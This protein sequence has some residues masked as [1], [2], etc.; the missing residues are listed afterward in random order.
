[1]NRY[2]VSGLVIAGL[3]L[4]GSTGR[5]P[6]QTGQQEVGDQHL[7]AEDLSAPDKT[8][9]TALKDG[10]KAFAP[11]DKRILDKAAQWFVYR[12]TWTQF[13]E[14]KPRDGVTLATAMSVYDMLNKE[15]YPLFIVP[16]PKRP[17]WKPNDNQQVYMA[18]FTESL[19]PAIQRVLKNPRPIARVNAGLILVKLSETGQEQI[20][21]VLLEILQDPEQIDA[22]KFYAVLALKNIFKGDPFREIER[23]AFVD[24]DLEAQC[25]EA[26]VKFLNR[27][28]DLRGQRFSMGEIDAFRYL[29]RATI[30]T[31]GETKFP[32]VA[33]RKEVLAKPA[34][35]LLR[36]IRKDENVRPAPTISEQVEAAIGLCKLQS[37]NYGDYQL[38]YAAHE[39]GQFLVEY[40]EMYEN[41]RASKNPNP[42]VLKD[43]SLRL[44]KALDILKD[45]S[46]ASKKSI[47]EMI[48]LGR[49]M[50]TNIAAGA[51]A[52]ELRPLRQL[53]QQN[54][55]SET[56]VYRGQPDSVIQKGG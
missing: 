4:A 16:D 55:P 20:A 36:I 18:R 7:V 23:D 25:I 32:A 10:T 33:K 39:L 9:L 11:G 15:L 40:G 5:A 34:L 21:P 54:P 1:M 56:S 22:V 8:R 50:L 29:R 48:R 26:L 12:I 44:A 46:K 41:D 14:R 43:D 19:L 27:K 38:E 24:K 53:L 28:P 2:C 51:Q 31:I 45:D 42:Q 6:A 37:R 13:Q 30:R 52:V 47:Q 3:L 49:G 35:E 17:S